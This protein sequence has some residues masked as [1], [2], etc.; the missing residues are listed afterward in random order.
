MKRAALFIAAGGIVLL[1][2]WFS[3]RQ[4]PLAAPVATRENSPLPVTAGSAAEPAAPV[5]NPVEER[6]H[7]ADDLNAPNGAIA[8]DLAVLDAVFSAWQTNFPMT[9]NP[10]GENAEIAAALTGANPLK[11]A[12]IPPDHPAVNSRG[13]LCDRWGTRFFFHQISARRMEIRSAGPD[14]RLYSDDDVVLTPAP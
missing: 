12:L 2:L 8:R 9:G 5:A 11:L 13:E 3:Q 1:A 7:L 4:P 14:R 10:V 6:S